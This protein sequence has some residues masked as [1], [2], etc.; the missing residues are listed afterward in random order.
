MSVFLL[1]VLF[2]NFCFNSCEAQCRASTATWPYGTSWAS[3]IQPALSTSWTGSMALI[4]KSRLAGDLLLSLLLITM[5]PG[6][7]RLGRACRIHRVAF[8]A[9]LINK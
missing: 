9:A 6:R 8:K 2:A 7:T 5:N 4:R 3:T 1:C